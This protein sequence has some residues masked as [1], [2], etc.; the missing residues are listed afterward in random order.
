VCVVVGERGGSRW[1]RR[2]TAEVD[3][4]TLP[5]RLLQDPAGLFPDA[6]RLARD[7]GHDDV[8]DAW[9]DDL[10]LQ[11]RHGRGR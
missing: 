6:E 8:L 2:R 10:H 11:R 5:E 4:A 9:G 1:L 3:E 7:R